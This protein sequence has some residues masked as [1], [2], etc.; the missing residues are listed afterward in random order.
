MTFTIIQPAD[1]EAAIDLLRRVPLLVDSPT[2]RRQR[3]PDG[4]SRAFAG[5]D[6]RRPDLVWAAVGTGVSPGP[7][8]PVSSR[9][10]RPCSTSSAPTT[11]RR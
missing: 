2:Q 5:G 1:V 6:F 8:S 11:R 10:P 3:D 7:S 9:A 4:L